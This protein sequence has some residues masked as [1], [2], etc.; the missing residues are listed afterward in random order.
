LYVIIL[1]NMW[2][3]FWMQGHTL[4]NIIIIKLLLLLSLN[5]FIKS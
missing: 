3:D 4:I 1:L 2:M 5:Y